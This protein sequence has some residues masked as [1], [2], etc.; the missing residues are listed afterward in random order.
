MRRRLFAA[1]L[2]PAVL[3]GADPAA[4]DTAHPAVVTATRGDH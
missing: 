3:L 1:L 4:A 2:I